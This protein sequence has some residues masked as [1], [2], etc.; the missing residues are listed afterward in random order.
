MQDGIGKLRARLRNYGY[1]V[2]HESE[3]G[4][5]APRCISL[6]SRHIP[7][8]GDVFEPVISIPMPNV[9]DAEK[10]HEHIKRL[11]HMQQYCLIARIMCMIGMESEYPAVF[12]L[13]RVGDYAM[14]K[15]ADMAEETLDEMLKKRA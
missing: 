3:V 8:A 11:D 6:E 1:W 4:P 2:L 10:L 7:D 15:L 5:A 12:K 13:R 9:A 14:E